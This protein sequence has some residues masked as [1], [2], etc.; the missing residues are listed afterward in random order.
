MDKKTS[1]FQ[2]GL[3]AVFLVLGLVGIIIFALTSSAGKSDDIGDVRLWGTF[4]QRIVDSF[5]HEQGTENRNLANVQY[6]EV[7][8][9]KFYDQLA[10]AIASDRGPDLIITDQAHIEKYKGTIKPITYE[11]ISARQFKDAFIDA[12]DVLTTPEGYLGIPIAV[13]P[14]M[15]YWNRE[16][17]AQNNIAQP[18]KYWDDLFSIAEKVTVKD[19]V[20]NITTSGVALGEPENVAH[21]KDVLSLMVMQAGGDVIVRTATGQLD[22]R[23]GKADAQGLSPAQSA[24]RY[25]SEFSNPSKKIYSWN[26]SM[27]NSL[28]AFVAGDLAIYLGTASELNTIEEKNP[29]LSFDIAQIPQIRGGGT[30]DVRTITAG[31][32]YVLAIPKTSKNPGGALTIAYALTTG[33]A[34]KLWEK[35][36]R[37]P[38]PQRALL[39]SDP[40]NALASTS[41]EAA[42]RIRLWPDPE[43]EKT[44]DILYRMVERVSS[45]ADRLSESVQRADAELKILLRDIGQ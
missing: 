34:S 43:P 17:F 4:D 28:E 18:P 23:L 32:L 41:R 10:Q 36:L 3:L 9:E 7:A 33:D 20:G 24:L 5:L 12:T 39:V 1:P 42:L 37:I 11:N 29:N 19:D 8:P 25:Y 6:S 15:L 16:I 14:L 21:S 40:K 2:I 35:K 38:S 44:Q 30:K 31:T 45:G 22:A 26:K 13:D 27:P